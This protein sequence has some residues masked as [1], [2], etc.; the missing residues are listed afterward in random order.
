MVV[1]AAVAKVIRVRVSGEV[2]ASTVDLLVSS[3][4][5]VRRSLAMLD[6]LRT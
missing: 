3:S 2:D 4:A 1:P 5:A 6:L